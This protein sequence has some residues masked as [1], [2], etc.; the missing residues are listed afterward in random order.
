MQDSKDD[1]FAQFWSLILKQLQKLR[2]EEHKKQEREDKGNGDLSFSHTVNSK[3]TI[4]IWV[5]EN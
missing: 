4:V 3:A 5:G 2:K 1:K